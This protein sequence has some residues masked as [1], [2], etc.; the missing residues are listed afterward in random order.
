MN[1]RHV[2]IGGSADAG[3]RVAHGTTP[4]EIGWCG[5]RLRVSP[6]DGLG[7]LCGVVAGR[8]RRPTVRCCRTFRASRAACHRLYHQTHPSKMSTKVK[9]DASMLY[10]CA[11]HSLTSSARPTSARALH[12]AGMGVNE[13]TKIERVAGGCPRRVHPRPRRRR[14]RRRELVVLRLFARRPRCAPTRAS[15]AERTAT[16]HARRLAS[17]PGPADLAPGLAAAAGRPDLGQI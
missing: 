10:L 15:G 7:R 12:A 9:R 1:E 2:G 8:C 3:V 11:P 14:P 6:S 4:G 13:R 5:S 16:A 17:R